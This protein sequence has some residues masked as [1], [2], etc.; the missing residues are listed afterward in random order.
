MIAQRLVGNRPGRDKRIMQKR[1]PTPYTSLTIPR[2]LT[3]AKMVAR[4]MISRRS[5]P[6]GS[7]LMPAVLTT[8]PHFWISVRTNAVNSA[9]GMT[10]GS[11]P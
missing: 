1:R 4:G 10:I 11:A 7:I 9:G 6:Q 5:S 8:A 3:S 2:E